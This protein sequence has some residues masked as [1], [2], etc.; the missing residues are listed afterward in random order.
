MITTGP[1]TD[2]D[3]ADDIYTDEIVVFAAEFYNKKVSMYRVSTIDG[4]LVDSRLI[5]AEIG[6]AYSV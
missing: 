4:S 1:D 5:D 2:I 3:V 6:H